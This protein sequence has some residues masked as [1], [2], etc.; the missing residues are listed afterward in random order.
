[1]RRKITLDAMKLSRKCKPLLDLKEYEIKM[2]KMAKM[3]SLLL[4]SR[5]L[6]THEE[7]PKP[8][9]S[10]LL[11]NEKNF[12]PSEKQVLTTCSVGMTA[13]F[14]IF[15]FTVATDDLLDFEE[16]DDVK[17]LDSGIYK[18]IIDLTED[19]DKIVRTYTRISKVTK[20]KY[21]YILKEMRNLIYCICNELHLALECILIAFIYLEKLINAS[22][23]ELR[24]SN[25]RPL[26][27]TSII[28]A[29]K[30]WEDCNFWTYDFSEFSNFSLRSLNIMEA[31]FIDLLEFNLHVP[32]KLYLVYYKKVSSFYHD[33]SKQEEKQL[34]KA[35]YR[36]YGFVKSKKN[37]MSSL[38]S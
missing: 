31:K 13:T 18:K 2:K 9:K 5:I 6:H 16:K 22:K 32:S 3:V 14:P 28:L 20:Q 7:R 17:A 15:Q 1:M 29:S 11:F 27:L 35:E 37:R 8:S 36:K 23:T 24:A 34:R 38:L 12:L 4:Y 10:A 30:Y 33:I 26:L 19:A 21:G 25:W